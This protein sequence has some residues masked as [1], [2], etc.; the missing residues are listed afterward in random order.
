MAR[1]NLL[2]YYGVLGASPGIAPLGIECV[3]HSP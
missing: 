2:L 1:I 3:V